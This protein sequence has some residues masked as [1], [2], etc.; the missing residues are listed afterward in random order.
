MCHQGRFD[1]VS[2]LLKYDDVAVDVTLKNNAG[3]SALDVARKSEMYEIAQCLEEYTK[4]CL[5]RREAEERSR[6]KDA[7]WMKGV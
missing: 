7:D 2:M 3:S 5:R 6:R 1:A 4:V